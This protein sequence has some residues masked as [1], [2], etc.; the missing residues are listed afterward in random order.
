[1]ETRLSPRAR[2][3][4]FWVL[5]ILMLA[6]VAHFFSL[7]SPFLWAIVTAYIFSPVINW[8]ARHTHLP[9]P[10]VATVV[11]V[12][13]VAGLIVGI[14]TLVPIIRE[15][16][17]DLYNQLP[18][19][20]GAGIDYFDQRFP[21]L[22]DRLG[23]DPDTLQK[24][25][26][27]IFNQITTRAPTTALTIAQRLFHFVIELFVYLIATFFFFVQGDRLV[28]GLRRS[29][30][31][32]FQREAERV[33]GEIN[34]TLGAYLRGQVLLV[35]IM[36]SVTYVVLWIYDIRYAFVLAL[37]TGFLE[38]IP[39]LGPWSAGAIAVSVAAFD[40]T[41]PFGWSHTT[42]AIVVGITYFVL[43][44]LE[45]NLVI[46]TLIGRIV[47]LHPLLMIVVLLIGTS[48][49]GILGLLLAVPIAAVVRILLRYLY[50]KIVA[51]AERQ[52]V[53]LDSHADLLAIRDELPSLTNAHVVLLPR[54]GALR[55]EDLPTVQVI[56]NL[57]D[58]FSVN[59]TIVTPD[60]IAGSLFTAVGLETAVISAERGTRNA[61]QENGEAGG[62]R[63]AVA[64]ASVEQALAEMR[65]TKLR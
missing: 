28:A 3:I 2:L 62:R 64:E 65:T 50:G 23:L 29:L 34:T 27:D 48:I 33:L 18:A 25:I 16:A 11:Y 36:T 14:V 12:A 20:T 56:A 54:P 49:G 58:R 13:I 8:I 60:T 55:W 45:D 24:Q 47:H 41:P 19:S 35:L 37:A 1:M 5:A 32:R 15:Q 43:R 51:D 57:A 44:Q 22:N 39:I 61:E 21:G 59:L 53:P 26:N 7:L 63:P 4:A 31:L 40:P 6:L 10:L 52:I 9:R 17:N 30:P 38:L 42:L 46:P